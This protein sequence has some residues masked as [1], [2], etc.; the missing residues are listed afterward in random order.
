MSDPSNNPVSVIDEQ[1]ITSE[2]DARKDLAL[3]YGLLFANC[4]SLE[5]DKKALVKF[6]NAKLAEI[7]EMKT[8]ISSLS[9]RLKESESAREQLAV[10]LR[11]RKTPTTNDRKP[12][13]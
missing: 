4:R 1:N 9:Q 12:K 3:E 5:L 10:Q 8:I 7:Q 11:G 13:K 2:V 6:G